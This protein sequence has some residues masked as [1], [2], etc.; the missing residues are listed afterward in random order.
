MPMHQ[1]GDVVASHADEHSG[2]MAAH[3]TAAAHASNPDAPG[4]YEDGGDPPPCPWMPMMGTGCTAPVV[5]PAVSTGFGT[6]DG[7]SMVAFRPARE[8]ATLHSSDPLLPPPRD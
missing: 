4:V 8:L 3:M 5:A 2:D 1:D 7:F 6:V